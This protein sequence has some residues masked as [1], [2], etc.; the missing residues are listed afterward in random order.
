[1]VP[2]MAAHWLA[3]KCP[4]G[5]KWSSRLFSANLATITGTKATILP[6]NCFLA[7]RRSKLPYRFLT[8]QRCLL[9]FLLTDCYIWELRKPA[10]EMRVEMQQTAHTGHSLQ[11]MV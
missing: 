7:R 4:L 3:W 11:F 5:R 1:M 6:I 9:R 10:N 2:I 8:T